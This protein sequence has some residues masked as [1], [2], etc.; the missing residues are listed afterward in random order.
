MLPVIASSRPPIDS[1][2]VPI[3]PVEAQARAELCFGDAD[4]SGRGGEV[5]LGAAHVGALAKRI[6]RNPDRDRRR[7]DRDR[8]GRG[9]S[10]Q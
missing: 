2:D 6:G 1:A 8:P 7:P 5:A 4:S 10:R 9:Q 3:L